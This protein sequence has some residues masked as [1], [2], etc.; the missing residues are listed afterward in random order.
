MRFAGGFSP[1]V[2]LVGVGLWTRENVVV[3]SAWGKKWMRRGV[4]WRHATLAG[5]WIVRGWGIVLRVCCRLRV[6]PGLY[7][8]LSGHLAET[9]INPGKMAFQP[10]FIGVEGGGRYW[11]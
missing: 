9:R 1:G 10:Y 2:S 6:G 3:P 7:W 5:V 11:T 8:A 4:A